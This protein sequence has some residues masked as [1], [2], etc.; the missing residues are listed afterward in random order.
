MKII[1]S[2]ESVKVTQWNDESHEKEQEVGR[3]CYVNCDLL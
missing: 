2:F 1:L 3:Q